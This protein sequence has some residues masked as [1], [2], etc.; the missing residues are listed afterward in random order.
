[1][2]SVHEFAG[3]NWRQQERSRLLGVD[4]IASGIDELGVLLMGNERGVF[5]YGSRLSNDEARALVPHNNAT[6]LQVTIPVL[7]GMVWAIENPRASIVDA[8][9][10]DYRRVLEVCLP[11]LGPVVGEWGQWSPLDHREA[12]FPEDI[13][14]DDPW[15]FRN[16]RVS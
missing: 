10:L 4:E 5:W 11:Y 3:R 9:E 1:V 15:Q 7:G 12:L 6:G 2:L 8:D 16:I 13:D 14:R